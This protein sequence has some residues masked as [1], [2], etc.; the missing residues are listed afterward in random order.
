MFV[1]I[2]AEMAEFYYVQHIVGGLLSV[3]VIFH[4]C[5]IPTALILNV[6]LVVNY[7][8]VVLNITAGVCT[9]IIYRSHMFQLPSSC[10]V[11]S[12]REEEVLVSLREEE[13]L[14]SLREEQ[15]LVSLR[16]EEVLVSLREEEVLVSLREEEVLVSLREEEVL[17]SLREEQV[18]VSLREEEVLVSL[19]EE[20]VLVSLREEQV[21]VSLREEQVLVSLREGLTHQQIYPVVV[22]CGKIFED[23][24]IN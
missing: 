16:E 1:S 21:L 15:V 8:S 18:L 3:C 19:R 11:V 2:L 10:Q 4:N 6:I 17:V 24:Q 13:V 5:G 23:L 7:K 12:L 20:Q 9:E 22:D 14:V